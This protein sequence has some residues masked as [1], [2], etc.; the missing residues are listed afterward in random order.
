M[1][2][3]KVWK[4]GG[5]A[6]SA[7]RWTKYVRLATLCHRI[8]TL[9]ATPLTS[10]IR[11][12]DALLVG[13]VPAIHSAQLLI[14]SP[15][16]SEKSAEP[17]VGKP[18]CCSHAYEIMLEGVGNSYAPISTVPPVIRELPSR[19]DPAGAAALKPALIHVE[20]LRR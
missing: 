7:A 12:A 14:R 11:K 4:F 8:V 10:S 13:I 15:S 19:S 3:A 20:L 18:Y 9:G 1:F 5:A 17:S 2:E 16:G 6:T